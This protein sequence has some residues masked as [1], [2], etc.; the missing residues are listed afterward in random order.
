MNLKRFVKV[1]HFSLSRKDFD[2][3]ALAAK[4]VDYLDSMHSFVYKKNLPTV[5]IRCIVRLRRPLSAVEMLGWIGQREQGRRVN[6][7]EGES[8]HWPL[9]T[10][11]EL[12]APSHFSNLVTA[13]KRNHWD[14]G[15]MGTGGYAVDK[16]RQWRRSA[17]TNSWIRLIDLNLPGSGY[18]YKPNLPA[19]FDYVKLRAFSLGASLTAVVAVIG[20]SPEIGEKITAIAKE[21]PKAKIVREHGY[22]VVWDSDR[23]TERAV[24]EYR[25]SIEEHAINWLSAKL[26]GLFSE[27]ESRHMPVI[28][29]MATEIADPSDEL[30]NDDVIRMLELGGFPAWRWTK[31]EAAIYLKTRIDAWNEHCGPRYVLSGKASNLA[32]SKITSDYGNSASIDSVAWFVSDRLVPVMASRIALDALLDKQREDIGAL[33]DQVHRMSSNPRAS[34]RLMRDAARTV[35]ADSTGSLADIRKLAEDEFHY[36]YDLPTFEAFGEDADY[37]EERQYSN[38]FAYMR[39]QHRN[40]VVEIQSRQQSVR[41]LLELSA[42]FNAELFMSRAQYVAIFIA[43]VSLVVALAALAV[44]VNDQSLV[45]VWFRSHF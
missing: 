33:H 21:V 10:V 1:D 40:Q 12:Y 41:E 44:S 22:P 18:L 23:V 29:F 7:P 35:F 42:T 38:F 27:G 20:L 13:L 8:V 32:A 11:V 31:D 28:S 37:L 4:G 34:S 16:L 36:F 43:V 5:F 45:I 39:E 14:R 3:F 2:K 25:D 17:A 15:F 6:V 30:A 26:P 9:V 24:E 19:E